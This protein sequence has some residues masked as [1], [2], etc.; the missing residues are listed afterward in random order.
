MEN[1]LL[2]ELLLEF[3]KF[4]K[5]HYGLLEFIEPNIEPTI[6]NLIINALQSLWKIYNNLIDLNAVFGENLKNHQLVNFCNTK[7]KEEINKYYGEN[8]NRT[9][10]I[11]EIEF[12]I[13]LKKNMDFC[14]KHLKNDTVLIICS[15]K[16]QQLRKRMSLP[17]EN[18][19]HKVNFSYCDLSQRNFSGKLIYNWNINNCNFSRSKFKGDG[20]TGTCIHWNAINCN[21]TDALFLGNICNKTSKYINTNFTRVDLT[22]I[23]YNC[24]EVTMK[25]CDFINTYIIDEK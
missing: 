21:F 5:L 4:P 16:I 6:H 10:D 15:N 17:F 12:N 1:K 2:V 24:S 3:I 19:V 8:P 7:F 25:N 11:T 22:T 23:L 14:F 18:L 13:E 20:S 9:K